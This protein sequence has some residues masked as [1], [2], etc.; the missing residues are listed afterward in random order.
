MNRSLVIALLACAVLLA[1]TTLPGP[2][3]QPKTH[4]GG[5]ASGL[6]TLIGSAAAGDTAVLSRVLPD[7]NVEEF[8]LPDGMVL[9][10]TD[11]VATVNGGAASGQMVGGLKP[12]SLAGPWSPYYVFDVAVETQRQFHFTA[13]RVFTEVPVLDHGGGSPA[14]VYVEVLGYLAKAK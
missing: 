2:S 4:L 14:G 6:L 8:T 10:V 12:P 5:K 7:G 3:A 13:G 11:L 9:V 1:A